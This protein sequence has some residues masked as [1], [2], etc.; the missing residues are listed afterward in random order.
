MKKAATSLL[1]FSFM[2]SPI[3]AAAQTEEGVS[4]N[5]ETATQT[6]A[7]ESATPSV[8]ITEPETIPETFL[9]SEPTEP[10]LDTNEPI[11]EEP[12]PPVEEDSKPEDSRLTEAPE[13]M[14]LQSSGSGLQSPE[15]A[16]KTIEPRFHAEPDLISGSLQYD[17]PLTL[18]PGRDGMEP[19]LRL[20]YSSQP[21]EEVNAFG[22]GWSLSIPYIERM[23]KK[24]T[25]SMY[26]HDY[27]YSSLD[28]ELEKTASSSSFYGPKIEGGAFNTYEF[29][30]GYWSITD[31]LGTRYLFGTTTASRIDNPSD[32]SQV[33]RWYLQEIRD[34]NGNFVNYEYAK[35][36]AFIYPS[37]VTYTGN[38]SSPGIFEVEF[39]REARTDIATSSKAG[40]LVTSNQRISEIQ[41]KV[42][43]SWVRKFV[44]S[45]TTA[46]NS[47]RSIINTITES[48]KDD[49]G[50]ITTLPVTDFDYR[51]SAKGW[52]RDTG[53][54][55]PVTFTETYTMDAGVRLADVNGDGLTDVIK[56][57][58]GSSAST[59]AVATYLNTGSGWSEDT[60]WD[61][62]VHFVDNTTD[63]HARLTDVNGDGLV[64][65]MQ[66]MNT[67]AST[68]VNRTFINNGT[69]WTEDMTLDSPVYFSESYAEDAGVR[70]A[71]VNGDGLVDIM[72]AYSDS[73]QSINK[74][75]VNNG[76][77]WTEVTIWDAPV[78]F[79]D[80]G[81]DKS[82][83]LED[84]N[85]DDL[86]DV[87]LA[88]YSSDIRTF[89]NNGN[90]WTE[91]PQ[92]D[93]PVVF[94]STANGSPVPDAGVRFADVN[95]DGLVDIVK[96]HSALNDS[97]VTTYI[98]KNNGWTED[99]SWAPPLSFVTDNHDNQARLA[100]VNGDGLLDI[101]QAL[102][103]IYPYCGCLI[104]ENIIYISNSQ[105]TDLLT[106][107]T[108]AEGGSTSITY[109]ASPQYRNGSQSLNPKLPLVLDTV[110]TVT[111]N[112]GLGSSLTANY[113]YEGGRYYY[114]DE[115]DKRFAGFETIVKTDGAGN[116]TKTNYHQGNTSNTSQGEYDDHP[117]K[118]G[119]EY[120]SESHDASSS[121]FTK[122]I[123]K[124]DKTNLGNGRFT[125]TLSQQVDFTH[126]GDSDHKDRAF[127]YT[128]DPANGNVLTEKTWG[129][130]V[131]SN[132]GTFADV[133]GDSYVT[134]YSYATSSSNY[135]PG[136]Q[137]QKVVID[138]NASKVREE[139]VYYDNLLSGQVDKGNVTKIEQWI[140]GTEYA[141]STNAFNSYGLLTDSR[142][143]RGGLTTYAYDTHN[144]YPVTVTNDK[145]HSTAYTY[146]YSSGSAT[147]ETDPNGGK[148]AGIYDGL[149]RLTSFTQSDPAS[150]S[151]L[152]TNTEYQY[153]YGPLPKIIRKEY[154]TASNT[155]DTHAYLDGFG[156]IVQERI[157]AEDQG[158]F[159]V[160][161]FKYNTQGLL[162]R[163]SL[164]YFDNGSSR[165]TPV[166]NSR[167]HIDYE[168]D[169][170][171]RVLTAENTIGTTQ[172]TYDDWSVTVTDARENEKDLRYDAHGNLIEVVEY[173]DESEY[174]TEYYFNGNGNIKSVIDA[175]GNVREFTYDGRGSLL[176]SQDAHATGDSTFGTYTFTYDLSGNRASRIDPKGQITNYVYDSLNRLVTEDF[177]TGSGIEKTF[178][179]DTCLNGVGKPCSALTAS[180][181]TTYQY[182]VLGRIT[183]ESKT[184]DGTAFTTAYSHDRQDNVTL[185]TYPD[186]SEAAYGYNGAGLLETVSQK[187]S[188]DPAH[189]LLISDFD[190]SP[191]DRIAMQT[192][193]NGTKTINT[194]D[195][196]QLYRLAVKKTVG[197][198]IG[199]MNQ[200]LMADDDSGMTELNSLRIQPDS[201][202]KTVSGEP[203]EIVS[204]RT[205]GS[206]TFST[207]KNKKGE[208]TY[209]TRF[210][211][212]EVHALN[213]SGK[214]VDINHATSRSE[215]ASAW[216]VYKAAY[217]LEIAKH[218]EANLLSYSNEDIQLSLT[219]ADSKRQN[220]LSSQADDNTYTFENIL[221]QDQNIEI[222]SEDSYITKDIVLGS[223]PVV[224]KG[225]NY[226]IT[227]KLTATPS[228]DIRLG[229]KLL[230][231][232]GTITSD[233]PAEIL[234][235]GDFIALIREPLAQDS[236]D[237]S[238]PGQKV[239]ISIRYEMLADGIYL[240]KILP[241]AWLAEATYP[242][243][244]D[245]SLSTYAGVGD[246]F[247]VTQPYPASWATQQA[248]TTGR[249]ASYTDIEFNVATGL[250]HAANGYLTI[251]RAYVPFDTSVLP[252][253]AII[254]SSTLKVYAKSKSN[255]YNDAHDYLNVYEGRQTSPTQLV[256]ADINDCGN[257]VTNPTK[258]SANVDITNIATNSYLSIPLNSSGLGWISKTG[259]TKL[260]MREGH[261]AVNAQPPS[262]TNY[263]WKMNQVIFASSEASGTS[264]DPYLEVTYTIPNAVP[265][266][267]IGLLAEGQTNP[268]NITD[269]TPEFNARFSDPDPVST[270]THY[271]IQVATSTSGW[272]S[273][274][275]DSTKTSLQVPLAS[276]DQSPN[277][278][279]GG[280]NFLIDG[281]T[282]NWRVRFWDNEGAQGAWSSGTD[283]FSMFNDQ[284]RI[285]EL[286]YE[287][288]EAGNTKTVTDYVAS[289]GPWLRQYTYDDLNRLT[290][291]VATSSIFAFGEFP[292][293]VKLTVA[294]SS[295]S[296]SL[297]NFPVLVDLANMP[298]AFWSHVRA[299]GGD[300]RIKD[301][302]GFSVP[303]EIGA[304][305]TA[306]STG[307]LYFKAPALTNA[308]STSFYL[309]YGNPALTAPLPTDVYGSR[310]VWSDYR[311]SW[312]M[313]GAASSTAKLK[314]EATPNL[315]LTE[316]GSPTSNTSWRGE[317]N[318]GYS[319][320]GSSQWLSM[321]DHADLDVGSSLS[322]SAY[323]KPV[324]GSVSTSD[325]PIFSR[326]NGT[327]EVLGL[328]LENGGYPFA[329]IQNAYISNQNTNYADSV[330][331]S[332]DIDNGQWHS[333]VLTYDNAT[334]RLYVDGILTATK[335]VVGQFSDDTVGA[336][337]G[338]WQGT[339]AYFS[340]GIDEVRIRPSTLS[341][342]WI[343][344]EH[345]N[346]SN[347][348]AFYS[349][350][351][352]EYVGANFS[353]STVASSYYYSYD[354][355]GNIASSSELGTY[356]YMGDQGINYANPHAVTAIAST[357]YAYDNNGNLT[358]DGQRTHQ[359]DYENS[360]VQTII[361][362]TTVDY[363][364]DHTGSRVSYREGG[365]ATVY[366]NKLYTVSPAAI[367]RHIYA[368]GDLVATIQ[369]VG[370]TTSRHYAHTDHLGGTDV[371]SASNGL[372]E[373]QLSYNPFGAISEH[374]R[375]GSFDERR[376]F[377]G[378]EF[379][380]ATGLNYMGMRYQDGTTGRFISQDPAHWLIGDQDFSDAY[381]RSLD[382]HL[383]NPQSLNSYSYVNNNPLRYTDEDG[384]IIPIILLA[385]WG[386][387][388]IGLTAYDGYT[389]LR[390]L[391]DPNATA[392]EKGIATGGFAAGLALPGG[393]YGSA[394]KGILKAASGTSKSV[395]KA[396]SISISKDGLQHVLN[397]HTASGKG[398]S[399]K[400]TFNSN[401][402]ITNLIKSSSGKNAVK[403][404]NGNY[405]RTFDTGKIIGTDRNTGKK[406]S[407]VTVITNKKGAL[408]T[409]FPGKPK[410]IKKK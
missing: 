152:L 85:N 408:V 139:K 146:D 399:G 282:Y 208:M 245:F 372:S 368:G 12:I 370:T 380:K 312:H 147:L 331:Y 190:Y 115:F 293:R 255:Y 51:L 24:G 236:S 384:Q 389:A 223:N 232:Y 180:A 366:P 342:S 9:E 39:L 179:Y 231:E 373:Q 363:G 272:S 116:K 65:I 171:G 63:Q 81:E 137:S 97:G 307:Y 385:A 227:F 133:T 8:L 369:T 61:A 349:T 106:K 217:G 87:I 193:A 266:A 303:V 276:G 71:D 262:N 327:T 219:L 391:T 122:R 400:S 206:K 317:A 176:T 1:L 174:T 351:M 367:E 104:Q 138:E 305:H 269:I 313:H 379:D 296:S 79:I 151:Q 277:I 82:V 200:I 135:S 26:S 128:Y 149:D 409:A 355:I 246:G 114:N 16:R 224:T 109:K 168:Y 45:Y 99:A 248:D 145:N 234:S 29:A 344:A 160:R 371:V 157:E 250:Y 235:R 401:V 69:G 50:T 178:S 136:Y 74:T 207:G 295:V 251:E 330:I 306:S 388:E 239:N 321:P 350:G 403:Q 308:T 183:S 230:S 201:N 75:F 144:L 195:P 89:I 181:S 40:F 325:R 319:L 121:L 310:N 70:L 6:Q 73:Q 5:S 241:S 15:L 279:Y 287:Y 347:P 386:A 297:S 172:R 10:T 49:I 131:G 77:G 83:R 210:F 218:S 127:S 36:G 23:N 153:S 215:T 407:I 88:K 290:S 30:N 213:S 55:L 376:K 220:V 365:V 118:I 309:Y 134:T 158:D 258:G 242:V 43:G 119:R 90:G 198:G 281:S 275:W 203:G 194:Y 196:D 44:L 338:T 94:S 22:Y 278:S 98:N 265:N 353:T 66:A 383:S 283:T 270:G 113:S 271:Q 13:S 341:A 260:C 233:R 402:N 182:D 398:S 100:D 110:E 123:S 150:P 345:K 108:H 58:Q 185:I 2:L 286:R 362:T 28:G 34:T 284:T 84:V 301:N 343:Q 229:D 80:N 346:I 35:N 48:G 390:T 396:P 221:G 404:S 322:L 192:N 289:G 102:K 187:G 328:A 62:P 315:S 46:D 37:K 259:Y 92:W 339:S 273:P 197:P 318:G 191:T 222:R 261:D 393:G 17:F 120:R 18:P 263:S 78:N 7:D 20:A 364:Y 27:F 173:N 226:E 32:S 326:R 140:T 59:T 163:E 304:I 204:M 356:A 202:I 211:N 52:T 161:D 240:T 410:P 93:S 252:D 302:S 333:A 42:N 125:S 11:Q 335:N 237:L 72:Q 19:E 375:S 214:F 323:F 25:D 352:E 101:V 225:G 316:N 397:N 348:S 141:S 254:A 253:N 38:G 57:Y 142:E 377:T 33:Y 320:S 164:P 292:Y 159:K 96:A 324:S 31:K 156:R 249:G 294:S 148:Q 381:D 56:S 267:P 111:L 244:A 21:S 358:S 67:T 387:V 298:S 291:Y 216:Q 112:S 199:T 257:T 238:N 336:S 340:G 14:S 299:D 76:N 107:V 154:L 54:Q 354:S 186:A 247:I 169:A 256:N 264:Q 170:L 205:P 332:T 212:K 405:Q 288:D 361:G 86:V 311:A 337:I 274:I 103:H 359:W 334:M 3:V 175:L 329:R 360:L 177:T 47:R 285:Q 314:N 124:W 126:D 132:D 382:F 53:L 4:A 209:S 280:N 41:A 228:L 95:G 406:T 392:A 188:A 357:T 162:A 130:V 105:K 155:V 378:H 64:D 91:N 395:S 166:S 243:R 394:G 68:S 189:T 374:L 117:S 143:P 60:S 129:E 167:L 165:T 300:I 268:T 184:V